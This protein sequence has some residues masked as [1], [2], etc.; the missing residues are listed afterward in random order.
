MH[1]APSWFVPVSLT[2]GLGII[3]PVFLAG[4]LAGNRRRA[5]IVAGSMAVLWGTG[6]ILFTQFGLPPAWISLPISCL[7]GPLLIWKQW[8]RI[9]EAL[10]SARVPRQSS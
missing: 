10:G 5:V 2:I 7:L 4:A 6:L 9:I 8:P 3:L 1:P